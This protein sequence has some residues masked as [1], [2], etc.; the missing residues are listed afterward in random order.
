MYKTL[1]SL[2][3]TQYFT[4]N[5]IISA[6]EVNIIAKVREEITE[7]LVEKISASLTIGY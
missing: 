7:L 5:Q 1:K 2:K 3:V 6:E 4:K